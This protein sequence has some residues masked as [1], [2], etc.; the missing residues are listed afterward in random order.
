MINKI[1]IIWKTVKRKLS[2]L[3]GYE[4][5]PRQL[6]EKDYNDLKKSLEKF[7]LAEIPAINTDNKIIAGHQRL[8]IL[9]ELYGDKH[10]IDVRIPNRKLTAK[11]FQEYNVRS[12]KNAGDWDFEILANNFEVDDLLDWGFAENEL[13]INLWN[14]TPEEKLDEVPEVETEAISKIGDL[15]LLDN[16][17]RLLCGDSTKEED[18]DKL[19]DGNKCNVIITSPPYWVGKDYELE[20][21]EGEINHFI[22]NTVINLVNVTETDY[23]RIIIN[24]GTSKS[25][26]LNKKNKPRTIL[27]ADKWTNELLKYDWYLRYI[28]HW[29]KGGG[30]ERPRR[31]IDDFV[32][33]GIEY[34]LTFYNINGKSRGQ[35]RLNEGWM[36]QSDW[37]NIKGDRQDNKA[38]YPVE[39]PLRYLKLYSLPNEIIFE[40]FTGNGTNFIACEQTNRICYGME[41]EPL[42]VDVTLKRYRN[43][44]PN[45]EIKCLTRKDFNFNKLFKP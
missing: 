38:G 35:N 15:F 7:D 24:T 45:K 30:N 41:L 31:P 20:K 23:S 1:K 17:H 3:K 10:T 34:L 42:Y 27:L 33:P 18:V 9:A 5:N 4:F 21:T 40:P 39:L 29:I 13:D 36:Q 14:D 25:T 8:K 16:K 32:Y 19:M 28:R 22:K 26:A 43:L 6:N 12:N 44:Y 2:E 11:E 37:T